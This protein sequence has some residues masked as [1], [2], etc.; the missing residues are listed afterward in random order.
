MITDLQRGVVTL[1]KSALDGREYPLPEQFDIAETVKIAVRHKIVGLIYYG[2]VQ[3]GIDRKC[4]PMQ[5]L[6]QLLVQTIAATERQRVMHSRVADKFE[7]NGIDYIPL[8]GFVLQDLYPKPEMRTMGD[9]DIL[10]RMEQYDKI[11]Q[12]M[13][14]LG[15]SFDHE[16]YHE[17][18]WKKG[19]IEIELHR[20][21]IPE[22]SKDMY[23]Y[24]GD[25]WKFAEKR[26]DRAGRY[27]LSPEN[28]Y[29]HTFAHLTKHYRGAGIGIRHMVDL[30]VYRNTSPNLNMDLV[31]DA[32]EQMGLLPFY[33]NVAA[34]LELW[35]LDGESTDITDTIT[36]FVFANGVF[37]CKDNAR[38]T[39][40]IK[41]TNLSGSVRKSKMRAFWKLVFPS[42]SI[43]AKKYSVLEKAAVMLPVM[44]VVRWFQVL[45]SK[46]EEVH[47]T[48]KQSRSNSQEVEEKRRMYELVGL[49]FSACE[50]ANP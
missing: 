9:A 26:G 11:R 6:F 21:M 16:Y 8:K 29:I 17:I 50:N 42:H 33:K 31:E 34:T 12:V 15:Y 41:D 5:K 39:S 44:W 19:N 1:I 14:E 2:A 47:T 49:D 23:A 38:I 10:I 48:I 35:F 24:F 32:L 46:P 40:L 20:S 37:G 25:G 4:E 45:F 28:F 27:D 7:E 43:M 18:A 30:W 22:T 13:A 3:C 36:E